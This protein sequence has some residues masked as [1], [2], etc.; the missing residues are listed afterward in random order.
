M[1][2]WTWFSIFYVFAAVTI[3][4][5]FIDENLRLVFLMI[6]F[7]LYVS[8]YNVY[9]SIKYYI[10]IR[11]EP[12]IR[13][14]RGDPGDFGQ[15]GTDGVCAMAKSCG[16]A[17]CRKL[18]VDELKKKFPEY[19]IIRKKL[20]KSEE[21]NPLEKKQNQQINSYIDILIPQC[22]IYEKSNA[23]SEQSVVDEFRKIIDTTINDLNP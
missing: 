21:L 4:Q 12:G 23:N 2:F 20:A 18:I 14:D 11:N 1:N 15:D 10:K 3:A 16:I 7:L 17:S 9:F 8:I 19:V 13:G 6:L 5:L 22:E